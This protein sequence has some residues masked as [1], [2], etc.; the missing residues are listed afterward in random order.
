MLPNYLHV[1]G[2]KCASTWLW[3]VYKEH[4]EIYVNPDAD[5]INFFVSDYDRGLDWYERT[6]FAHAD[7]S[8]VVGD[9][10]N[11]YMVF[12]PALERA[13]G[14]LP[15]ST[16]VTVTVRNPLDR[17]LIHWAHMKLVKRWAPDQRM[18][19]DDM[20]DV[21]MWQLFLMWAGPSYFG[22]HLENVYACF[23][24]DRVLV[25][26]YEDL[27]ADPQHYLETI[28]AFLEVDTSFRPSVLRERVGFPYGKKAADHPTEEDTS[29]VDNGYPSG[30][31]E[32][33]R[34][35]FEDDIRKLERLTGRDLGHWV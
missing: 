32:R 1:G 3:T 7:A 27:V 19:L 16:K 25:L 35:L 9:M 22:S 30:L 23:P 26:F 4:P 2:A 18:E 14:D 24:R 20:L 10:S 6:Y 33:L 29:L 17:T 28:F 5:N 8:P 11:S 15:G 31:R 34:G 21:H 12:P 13:A